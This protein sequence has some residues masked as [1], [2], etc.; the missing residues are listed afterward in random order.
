MSKPRTPEREREFQEFLKRTKGIAFLKGALKWFQ[1]NLGSIVTANELA[2]IPGKKGVPINH[3]MRR[4]TELKDQ[5]GYNIANFKNNKANGLNLK[6][7]E[8]VLLEPNPDP[9][10]IRP[11]GVNKRIMVEVFERDMSTCQMCGR[12]PEDDDP[13]SPGRKIKLHVGHRLAHKRKEGA[14]FT[15]NTKKLTKNDFITMCNVCNEGLKNKDFKPITM[16]DRIK[17]LPPEEKEKILEELQKS[18]LK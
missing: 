6:V 18:I 9:R 3:N 11:R 4:V 5:F 17:N 2:R 15:D 7:D 10:R 12:T 13:F 1:Q 14:I 16:I 8:W